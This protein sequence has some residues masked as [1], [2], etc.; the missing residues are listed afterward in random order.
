MKKSLQPAQHLLRRLGLLQAVD[1]VR[2]VVN[3]Y[4]M[5]SINTAFFRENPDFSVPP[6]SLAFDAYG[7][8][9][10]AYYHLSGSHLAG[11][12]AATVQQHCPV[13]APRILEWGCGPARVIRHLPA[14]FSEP[15]TLFGADYN[16]ESIAWASEHVPGVSFYKNGLEPPLAYEDG[17]F[18]FIYAL[19][20]F[21]HLSMEVGQQWMAELRRLLKPGG[22]LLFSTHGDTVA[23]FLLPAEREQYEREGYCVRDKVP[24]GKKMFSAWHHADYIRSEWLAADWELLE[25]GLPGRYRF[26]H[27]QDAWLVRKPTN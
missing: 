19:S 24:E 17:S 22:V 7:K 6:A 16:P 3:G 8:I 27:T 13:E 15:E 9:D 25:H 12:L 14:H 20:V 4:K 26:I 23:E 18:D 21:T 10:W 5:R 11:E 2:E 1:R